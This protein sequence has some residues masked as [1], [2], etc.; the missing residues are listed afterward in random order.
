MGN[1][2]RNPNLASEFK[3]D[4][5]WH[6]FWPKKTVKNWPNQVFWKFSTVFWPQ[7]GS[8]VIRFEFW[9]QIWIPLIIS[10]I[11]GPNLIEFLHFDF[12]TSHWAA[13]ILAA[14][15]DGKML[16]DRN[17]ILH[18][19]LHHGIDKNSDPARQNRQ[20]LF[21]TIKMWTTLPPTHKFM[22]L[23]G[24]RPLYF[25]KMKKCII[26]NKNKNKK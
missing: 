20:T 19:S 15:R 22:F 5:I 2:E 7:R 12:L 11:L 1:N 24:F 18:R 26:K 17:E 3:S 14:L 23:L 25:G 13:K 6:H 8:D 16:S 21:F 9:G 10:H 4:N